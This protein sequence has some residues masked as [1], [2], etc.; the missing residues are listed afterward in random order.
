MNLLYLA[1]WGVEDGLTV[2]VIYPHLK[3][4][5]QYESVDKIIF[6]TIER[7][8]EKGDLDQGQF[9]TD[10]IHHVGMRSRNLTP[11]LLNKFN[12]FFLFPKQLKG[13]IGE[14]GIDIAITHGMVSGS[15]LHLICPKLK[16]PYYV[17]AE[18]HSQYMLESGV[19]SKND[20]R[21]IFQK[22]WEHGQILSAEGLFS[23]TQN[24]IEVL[25]RA[26]GKN[27]LS[28]VRLAPNAVELEDFKFC[29]ER[30]TEIRTKLNIPSNSVVGIYVGK[31]GGIYLTSEVLNIFR[32]AK[33]VFP[34]FT[35]IVLS[36]QHEDEISGIMETKSTFE[37][38]NFRLLKVKHNEVPDYLSAA[39]FGFSM[40]NPKPSNLFLCPLKNG[41][42]WAS[43]LPIY[44]IDQ[45]GDDTNFIRS[46][47]Q[48]GVIFKLHD[49]EGYLRAYQE[50]KTII[51]H[52]QDRLNNE[53]RRAALD[54]RNINRIQKIFDE[55]LL[56]PSRTH[57]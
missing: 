46:N 10:K 38:I 8:T 4:I 45:V 13:L 40:Q 47:P 29:G 14:H 12:D 19:W 23:V 37:D 39:D 48:L 18:P 2:S 24:Y 42:Y 11:N 21:Y 26:Y 16:V 7:G 33:S 36:P 43:G 3:L 1:Y 56:N 30:R 20:P 9:R 28:K 57:S 25:A 54:N 17:F 27:I 35:L 22:K 49:A 51:E 31:F 34:D 44:C 55:V 5:E 15:L 32:A 6:V 50:I 41:E 53:P 52:Q